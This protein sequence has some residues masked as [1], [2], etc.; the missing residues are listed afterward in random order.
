MLAQVALVVALVTPAATA[1]QTL[2]EDGG[3][4]MWW[5]VSASAGGARL[6]C[7]VCDRSRDLGPSLNA[8]LGAYANPRLRVGVE[9]GAWT[10]E[11]GTDRE[12]VYRA[13]IVTQLHPRPGSGLH[14]VAGLG[15]SGYR[16]D[17]FT[18]DGV[19]LTLG[20]GWDLRLTD[21]WI[22]GNRVTLDGS[23][24][25]SLKNG[26]TVVERSAG[27]SVLRFGVHLRRR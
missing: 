17:D 4:G 2:P 5:E 1:A 24:Y 7:P 9:V 21:S 22:V 25:A 15:W 23:S 6:S 12:T 27:L 20:A 19:R 10:N 26:D 8:A 18:Y 16:A 14:V 13:G 11:D 3:G